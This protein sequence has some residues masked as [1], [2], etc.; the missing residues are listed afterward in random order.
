M[1]SLLD[2]IPGA[3]VAGVWLGAMLTNQMFTKGHVDDIKE[4]HAKEIADKD[5]QI[6][7][8]KD[9]VK[10]AEQRADSERRRGDSAVEAVNTSNLLLAGIRKGISSA[11]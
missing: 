9:A 1:S 10:F 3:G 7:E 5:K 4:A 8:L 2:I 11:D 6:A